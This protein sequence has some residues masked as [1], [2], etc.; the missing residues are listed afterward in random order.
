MLLF[1]RG[2]E[3]EGMIPYGDLRCP[4][5]LNT[6]PL[7]CSLLVVSATEFAQTETERGR[8]AEQDRDGALQ[9]AAG[10]RSVYPTLSVFEQFDTAFVAFFE[11]WK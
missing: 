11:N 3:W 4:K 8:D 5:Q 2:R 10:C 9:R 6:L 1:S 7:F